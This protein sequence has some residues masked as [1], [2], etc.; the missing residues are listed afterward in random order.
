MAF[1][2]GAERGQQCVE[3][4]R[5]VEEVGLV[6]ELKRLRVHEPHLF[7][8]RPGL[9]GVLDMRDVGDMRRLVEP[10]GHILA[11]GTGDAGNDEQRED[12]HSD[13][14]IGCRGAPPIRAPGLMVAERWTHDR[15]ALRGVKFSLGNA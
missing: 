2:L 13:Q 8:H 1:K 11:C 15:N 3:D 5:V 7:Q 6:G 12:H 4:R 9:A 14:T 10:S